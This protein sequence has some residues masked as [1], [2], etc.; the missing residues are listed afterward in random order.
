M[1]EAKIKRSQVICSILLM[2]DKEK[3]FYTAKI[4]ISGHDSVEV[5]IDTDLFKIKMWDEYMKVKV[6]SA[7]HDSF[8]YTRNPEYFLDRV[9]EIIKKHNKALSY[10][11]GETNE[12]VC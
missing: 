5:E 8:I 10:L 2:L 6:H 11:K 7:T 9:V 1:S 3:V 4:N 12:E